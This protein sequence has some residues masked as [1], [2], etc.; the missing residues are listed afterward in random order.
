MEVQP[1][2]AAA[3]LTTPVAEESARGALRITALAIGQG[4]AT[5]LESPDGLA[6]LIDAGPPGAG[7]GIVLPY[8]AAR[9]IQRLHITIASHYDSDHI[10]GMAEVFHGPDQIPQT[11]DD[12]L[13]EACWDR[14]G[15]IPDDHPA[16]RLYADRR[17]PCHHVL[18]PGERIGLGSEV[19]ITVLAVNGRFAD[20]REVPLDP[21]DENAHSAALLIQYGDFLYL[22]A[23]DLPGG[24][25]KPPYETIDLE[26]PLL[27]LLPR[28]QVLH[29]SHH[30]SRTATTAALLQAAAPRAAIISA[31]E[32]NPYGHPHPSIVE[33]LLAAQIP[34][35]LTE[36]GREDLP[37]AI[38]VAGGPI[39]VETDGKDFRIDVQ[40][41]TP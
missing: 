24:G 6:A 5:L 34:I 25:G 31:G 36:Q 15:A 26:T 29:V 27:P 32:A 41:A 35:Y 13:P 4:D 21:A 39:V 17:V 2:A 7:A 9:G 37:A 18:S 16:S 19:A 38:S 28:L 33:R 14:G 8:L 23:G 40:S 20:G 3:P 30:G 12:L 1:P 22:T 10:G 11:A